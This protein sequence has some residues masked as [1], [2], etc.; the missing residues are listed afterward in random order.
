VAI[1][2]FAGRAG[3]GYEAA[4]GGS[5]LWRPDGAVQARAGAEPG[6]VARAALEPLGDATPGLG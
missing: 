1:A 4:P 5:G 2:S 3:G 6:A